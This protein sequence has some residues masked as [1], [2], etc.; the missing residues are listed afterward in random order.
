[1]LEPKSERE[2]LTAERLFV[3]ARELW[4]VA[5]G[6]TV[7]RNAGLAHCGCSPR[8]EFCHQQC[9]RTSGD[10][11]GNMAGIPDGNVITLR[12]FPGILDLSSGCTGHSRT[13]DG[14]DIYVRKRD[15]IRQV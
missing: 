6:R 9:S 1:M 8:T 7:L 4:N 13:V 3:T 5:A 11:S 14:G 2:I 12:F 10:R 15:A